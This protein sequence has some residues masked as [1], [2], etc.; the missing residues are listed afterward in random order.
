MI[1]YQIEENLTVEEFKTVLERSTLGEK[2]PINDPERLSK[3]IEH[4]NLI[5]TARENGLL[6]NFNNVI[7]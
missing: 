6:I 7:F 2:R 4:G 5:V 1:Q 3:M